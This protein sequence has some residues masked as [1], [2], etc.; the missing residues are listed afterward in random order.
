MALSESSELAKILTVS[1]EMR[2][3][4]LAGCLSIDTRIAK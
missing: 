4:F 2:R 3:L 1:L